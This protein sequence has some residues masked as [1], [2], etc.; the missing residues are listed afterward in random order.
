MKKKITILQ[1][2]KQG[3]TGNIIQAV[4]DA[5]NTHENVKLSML[6]TATR[7]KQEARE[8][9]EKICQ[10]LGRKYTYRVMGYTIFIKEWRKP[11]RKS[12]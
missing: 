3:L 6:R 7:S 11:R 5:F 10:Q 1:V 8:I 9:A 2:G 12:T 4:R